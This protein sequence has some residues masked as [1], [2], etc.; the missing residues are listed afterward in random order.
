MGERARIL[1]VDDDLSLLK[2]LEIRLQREGYNVKTADSGK[3]ALAAL[4]AFRPQLVITDMRMDGMD[5]FALFDAIR[6][7]EPTVP[8]I[9]LTA[10]GTIP[11]AVDATQ[12]GMFAYLTKPF[13]R[14]QLIEIIERAL[15]IFGERDETPTEDAEWC[16][17]IITRSSSMKTLLREAW[18]VSQSDSS[19]L[20]RGESGTGKELL[21]R[22]IHVAGARKDQPLIAV[23]CTAI[24]EQLFE[25]ELFGH[26]KGA[27]T[28]ATQDR[29]GLIQ[30]ANAGT[31]FLDEIGDMPLQFQAK[32]LRMLQE[33]EI[34]PVGSTEAVGVDVR[35][36]SA[37]HQNL[38]NAIAEKTFRQDLYYRLNVVTLE[39]PPLARRRQDIP[40]LAD[41][42]LAR[43]RTDRHSPAVE[44]SG[45]AKDAMELLMSAAWP[46]NIRQLRN[47][48][49][50]CVVLATAPLIP[51]SLVERALRRKE[52]A[53]L[54][55]AEARDRFE[56]DYLAQLL[57]MTE[58]NVAQA[59]RLAERNRSEF[60]KLLRKHALEPEFFRR[61]ESEKVAV[62]GHE[63]PSL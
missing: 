31:L 17:E 13:E 57:E 19:V 61:G 63:S 27:F 21:A 43:A 46:G 34:R 54:P 20:I 12:R 4:P 62:P 41:H 22:A 35:I 18:M 42:F 30:A 49:D 51:A 24:P 32:L 40:L 50:Q 60:Y 26:K 7:K 58:G 25:A 5:G 2:V 10:H 6:D 38:E 48:V 52:K 8:V 14:E 39:I 44:V 56:F 11:D 3:K 53:F 45:F 16:S 23:N 47:V 59:A 29:T 33:E 55:F 37:T 9:V 28:G 36:I 1:L 15:S